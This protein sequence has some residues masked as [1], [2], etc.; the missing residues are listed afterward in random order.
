MTVEAGVRAADPPLTPEVDGITGAR[1][2]VSGRGCT[3]TS[4]ELG[5]GDA[6]A[7]RAAVLA[8]IGVSLDDAVFARQVHAA[9]VVRVGGR[10]RGAGARHAPTAVGD[11][12]ALITTEPGVA[13]CVQVA[14]CVPIALV[15]ADADG[16][17]CGVG[18]VHAGRD[19]IT[20]GV[21]GA[22][23]AALAEAATV[24]PAALAA[25]VGPAIGGCC[26]EVATEMAIEVAARV[27]AARARTRWDTPALDLPAAARAQLAAAGVGRVESVGSCT[28]CEPQRWF[29][30]RAAQAGE[31][32]PG[33]QV[34]AAVLD[35]P[36]GL[37][38]A[39]SLDFGP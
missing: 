30:H 27:P 36:A 22:A 7:A 29:S 26:Y 37:D 11:T 18:V 12:D 33:R 19:G 14:D 23:V 28:R 15:A 24:S 10:E 20:A 32:A 8:R 25:V 4:L 39:M 6:P 9:R 34:L 21:V 1:I 2:V 13:V 35:P 5:D 3:N 31:A 16:S 38:A 17:A